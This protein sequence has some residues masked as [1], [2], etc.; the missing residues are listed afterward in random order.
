MEK[1]PKVNAFAKYL[2]WLLRHGAVKENY[3]I[4]TNGW[5]KVDDILN[6]SN[7]ITFAN[8]KTIVENDNKQRFLLKQEDGS[9]SIKANQGHTID[10]STEELHLVTDPNEI[11]VAI[12]GTTKEAYQIIAK[13]GL[14]KMARKHIHMA[15]MTLDEFKK[16]GNQHFSGMR[17][18]SKVLIYVDVPKAMNAGLQFYVSNNGV[19]LTEGPIS[20]D[21]FLTVVE[22]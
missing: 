19:I 7:G 9:W 12:H 4:D 6:R 13:E 17:T 18:T 16:S 15:S 14:N 3:E 21:L 20:P 5:I 22:L 1:Q 8:I 2:S 10:V 11:P